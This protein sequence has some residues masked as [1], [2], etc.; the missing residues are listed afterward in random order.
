MTNSI[1]AEGLTKRFGTVTAVDG[2]DLAVQEGTV[3][4]LLGSNGAGKPTTVGLYI[5]ADNDRQCI[6]VD[7]QEGNTGH[8]LSTAFRNV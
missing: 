6:T 2:M 5:A 4:G 3:F 7:K 1:V 8:G